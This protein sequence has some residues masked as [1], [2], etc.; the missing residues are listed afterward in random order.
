[1]YRRLC[2]RQDLSTNEWW[3]LGMECQS[4][5]M[6]IHRAFLSDMGFH[7]LC[8]MG[9]WQHPGPAIHHCHYSRPGLAYHW[10]PSHRYWRHSRQKLVPVVWWAMSHQEHLSRDSPHTLVPQHRVSHDHRR[11]LAILSHQCRAVLYFLDTVGSWPIHL[12]RNPG[13]CFPYTPRCHCEYF[14]FFD[15]LPIVLRGLSLVVE[16]SRNF[17]VRWFEILHIKCCLYLFFTLHRSTGLFVFAYACF[18][19]I[20]RS[21]MSGGLQTI[22]FFGYTFM[23][24]YMFF[25][26]LGSVGYYSSLKFIRYIYLNIKMDWTAVLLKSPSFLFLFIF[27]MGL[28]LYL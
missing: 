10:L 15:I 28:D 4:N 13:R 25:L 20:K 11:L 19:Y 21:N 9:I 5:G 6:H 12:V 2:Q 16:I 26:M 3:S 22:Q 18:F 7:Q 17:R 24:C 1:M 23:T 14:N 27:C 8:R